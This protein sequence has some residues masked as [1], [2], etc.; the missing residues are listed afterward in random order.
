[1]VS[2]CLSTLGGGDDVPKCLEVISKTGNDSGNKEN[3]REKKTK[4][5]WL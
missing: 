3:E 4:K 1:M 5:V 2:V